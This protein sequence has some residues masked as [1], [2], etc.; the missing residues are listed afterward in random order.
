MNRILGSYRE[1][2]NALAAQDNP[3]L[4]GVQ[5]NYTRN[6]GL[7]SFT[8]RALN[9][10]TFDRFE[11]SS[12]GILQWGSGAAAVDTGFYRVTNDALAM[13]PGDRF[14]MDYTI[15]KATDTGKLA[16]NKEYVDAEILAAVSESKRFA[17]FIT[18]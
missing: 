7:N 1:G 2:V 17:F 14:Y 15:I 12:T 3:T 18:P 8:T 5:V 6:R 11:V 16:T 9:A 10:D 4:D 13:L